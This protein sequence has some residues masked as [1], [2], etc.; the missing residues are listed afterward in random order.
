MAAPTRVRALRGNGA[1]AVCGQADRQGRRGA[2]GTDW[3]NVRRGLGSDWAGNGE[4]EREST[5][6]RDEMRR[7]NAMMEVLVSVFV[8][9]CYW[10]D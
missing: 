9:G 2:V 10:R 1:T 6:D 8:V 7:V 4:W 3:A 5:K